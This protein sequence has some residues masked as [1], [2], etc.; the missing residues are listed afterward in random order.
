MEIRLAGVP[1][2]VVMRSPG[3][4]ENLVLGFALTEGIILSPGELAGVSGADGR[5]E[6][7]L[8]DGVTVDPEQF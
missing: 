6:L 7:T 1:I 5:Y 3:D 8:A 2:A 4:D